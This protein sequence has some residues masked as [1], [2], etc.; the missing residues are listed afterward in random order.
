MIVFPAIDIL[1]GKSVR[2]FK[3]QLDRPK[4]YYSDPLKPALIFQSAGFTHLHLVDLDGARSGQPSNLSILRR[5]CQST[6]LVVQYGGGLRSLES[7]EETLKAGA[8]RVVLGTVLISRPEIA[9]EIVEK[10]GSE[11][12]V[13]A[14]DIQKGKVAIEGWQKG[15]SF[16][17]REL[18]KKVEK[19]RPGHFLLTDVEQ[20]GTLTGVNFKLVEKLISYTNVPVIISGGVSSLKDLERATKLEKKGV[21]GIIIGKAFYENKIDLKEAVKFNNAD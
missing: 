9:E 21:E 5:I 20:D 19:L 4:V 13:A 1:E 6:N 17:L 15:T 10:Y 2:L 8:S 12:V 7:V 14:L 3:G 16:G 18:V 11:R